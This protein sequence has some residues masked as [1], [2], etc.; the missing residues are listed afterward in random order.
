M[1]ESAKIH[2]PQSQRKNCRQLWLSVTKILKKF[3]DFLL[4]KFSGRLQS[5][6]FYFAK[7]LAKQNVLVLEASQ[8]AS[9]T[10]VKI[11]WRCHFYG[12]YNETTYLWVSIY[13]VHPVTI[14]QSNY[15]FCKK[16]DNTVHI[17]NL[18]KLLLVLHCILYST[19]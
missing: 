2:A 9:H 11:S 8:R 4:W 13:L 1:S 14:I 16:L 18:T 19:L 10:C 12:G 7:N 17:S 3:S 15:C 6:F 5:V